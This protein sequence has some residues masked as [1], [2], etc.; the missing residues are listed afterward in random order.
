MAWITKRC[1][2]SFYQFRLAQMITMVGKVDVIKLSVRL[3]IVCPGVSMKLTRILYCGPRLL[4][5]KC[6]PGAR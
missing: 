6:H 5:W 4:Q 2:D 3:V 1:V